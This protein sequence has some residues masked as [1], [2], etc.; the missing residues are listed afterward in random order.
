MSIW[1]LCV[2]E[3]ERKCS[4]DSKVETLDFVIMRSVGRSPREAN[5]E[6]EE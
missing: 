1:F 5:G 3:R 4:V 2:K 6:E